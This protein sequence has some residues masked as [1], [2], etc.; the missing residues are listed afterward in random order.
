MLENGPNLNWTARK[1]VLHEYFGF[2]FEVYYEQKY[3]LR[4]LNILDIARLGGAR[5]R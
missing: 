5:E 1:S 3:F 4:A 2:N